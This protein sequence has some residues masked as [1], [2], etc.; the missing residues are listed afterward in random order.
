MHDLTQSGIKVKLKVKLLPE[1]LCVS[2]MYWNNFHKC[3]GN[4]EHWSVH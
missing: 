2:Q 1:Y 4:I 3:S